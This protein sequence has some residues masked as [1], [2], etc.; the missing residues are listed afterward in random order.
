MDHAV[1]DD[2][3][4][5]SGQSHVA[6]IGQHLVGGWLVGQERLRDL[7]KLLDL[8]GDVLDGLM[9]ESTW[10]QVTAPPFGGDQQLRLMTGGAQPQ[11]S[12]TDAP[13]FQ[14][15]EVDR[16]LLVGCL[17]WSGDPQSC[18]LIDQCSNR[19]V[20]EADQVAQVDQ[21]IG[22]CDPAKALCRRLAQLPDAPGRRRVRLSTRRDRS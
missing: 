10:R 15:V 13:R 11:Q 1:A 20:E 18:P 4:H 21:V 16:E 22:L 5:R 9:A 12:L 3:A 2:A 17:I 6:K 7:D 19:M 8:R 14:S